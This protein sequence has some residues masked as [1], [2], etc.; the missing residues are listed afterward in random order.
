MLISNG[1]EGRNDSP[2]VFVKFP[3]PIVL[4]TTKLLY[5]KFESVRISLEVVIVSEFTIFIDVICFPAILLGN[6]QFVE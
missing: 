4:F 1:A 3:I 6:K 5:S 2:S